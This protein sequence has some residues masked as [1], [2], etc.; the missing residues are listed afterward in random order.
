M[1]DM[2]GIE[3]NSESGAICSA[4]TGRRDLS[5]RLPGP[6]LRFSPGYHISGFQPS[7][8]PNSTVFS[9]RDKTHLAHGFRGRSMPMGTCSVWSIN[10]QVPIGLKRSM[11][12]VESEFNLLHSRL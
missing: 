8:P 3:L 10:I 1:N 6:P 12:K 7:Q 4:L 9:Q 2:R 11:D 5:D